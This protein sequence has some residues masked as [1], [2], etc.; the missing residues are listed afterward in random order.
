[1][2]CDRLVV[3][4]LVQKLVLND[5]TIVGA[6]DNSRPAAVFLLGDVEAMISI[7]GSIVGSIV[8]AQ[9][10]KMAVLLRRSIVHATA[11]AALS[12]GLRLDIADCTIIDEQSGT[13]ISAAGIVNSITPDRH[14]PFVSLSYGSDGYA[15]ID[16]EKEKQ[17]LNGR[18]DGAFRTTSRDWLFAAMRQRIAE[19]LPIEARGGLLARS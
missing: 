7:E 4:P 10:S 12:D 1:M 15:Q 3:G 19:N 14:T 9:P 8:A 2:S 17:Q 6:R 11:V 16:H 5:V 18:E 13:P